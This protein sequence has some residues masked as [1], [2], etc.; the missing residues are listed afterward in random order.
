M[1]EEKKKLKEA[2]G[3]SRR[4]KAPADFKE[5]YSFD[6]IFEIMH[7]VKLLEAQLHNKDEEMAQLKEEVAR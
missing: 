7:R 3:S 2:K 5:F 6:N 1:K 4:A